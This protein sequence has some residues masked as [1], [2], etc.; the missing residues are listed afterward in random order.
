MFEI[1]APVARYK[2]CNGK[3]NPHVVQRSRGTTQDGTLTTSIVT[4][5]LLPR[6]DQPTPAVH[7]SSALISTH[8]WI[9]VAPIRAMVDHAPA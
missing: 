9:P 2:E 1:A 3:F 8:A 4:Q 6:D 7:L 5:T